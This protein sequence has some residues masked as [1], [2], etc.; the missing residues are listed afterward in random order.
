LSGKVDDQRAVTWFVYPQESPKNLFLSRRSGD[1]A[2]PFSAVAVTPQPPYT[3]VAGDPEGNVF[4]FRIE[5]LER[6]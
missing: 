4:C 3:C 6:A 5:N 2:G 1:A